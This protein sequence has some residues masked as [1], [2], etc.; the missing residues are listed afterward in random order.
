[1]EWKEL[2]MKAEKEQLVDILVGKMVRDRYFYKEVYNEF[3]KEKISD[4]TATVDQAIASYTKEVKD[5]LEASVRSAN[6][7]MSISYDLLEQCEH[8]CIIDQIKLHMAVLKELGNA[9]NYALAMRM[10]VMLLYLTY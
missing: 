7:L 1:M 9:L 2:L 3:V 4:G 6:Y 10:K 8:V 5:E